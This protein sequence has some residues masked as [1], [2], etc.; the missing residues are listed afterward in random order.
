MTSG[1]KPRLVRQ[2][3]LL[4]PQC[5]VSFVSQNGPGGDTPCPTKTWEL[6]SEVIAF[7]V[8]NFLLIS[9]PDWC[10]YCNKCCCWSSSDLSVS[11][12]VR[13]AA[14]SSLMEV[15]LLLVQ[16]EAELIHANMYVLCCCWGSSQ[17][18][19]QALQECI[20]A[21]QEC[22]AWTLCAHSLVSGTELWEKDVKPM[23][24]WRML[25]LERGKERK[26][27]RKKE[28]FV[29]R[30]WVA[31]L[32]WKC[33]PAVGFGL[34][35]PTSVVLPRSVP[36]NRKPTCPPAYPERHNINLESDQMWAWVWICF[37]A[38]LLVRK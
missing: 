26:K 8:V 14:M 23:L 22:S 24:M 19:I 3:W 9:S 27:E 25:H 12:R 20:Q 37:F 21:L 2:G 6:L 32:P 10:I 1:I 38:E 29:G 11:H 35:L 7:V 36:W 16:N 33:S 34:N 13:E 18:C 15:T 4:D 31:V 30:T 17:K 28:K 5:N